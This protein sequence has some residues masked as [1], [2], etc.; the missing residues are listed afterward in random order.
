VGVYQVRPEVYQPPA[1][2]VPVG[3]APQMAP[4]ITITLPAPVA[5]PAPFNMAQF[6]NLKP[7]T[8]GT[9]PVAAPVQAYRI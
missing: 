5:Q 4:V 1:Y 8:V 3:W 2:Q 9:F 7:V 6:G